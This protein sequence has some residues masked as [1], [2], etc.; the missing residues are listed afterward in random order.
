M[1]ASSEGASVECR[2]SAGHLALGRCLLLEDQ[3]QPGEAAGSRPHGSFQA[4][5]QSAD[6]ALLFHSVLYCP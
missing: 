5:E 2:P 6:S 3:C 1:L 4:L